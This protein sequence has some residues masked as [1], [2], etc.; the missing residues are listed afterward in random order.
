MPRRLHGL[1]AFLTLTS[2]LLLTLAP[3]VG[4]ALAE[5]QLQGLK[6]L[7]RQ[8]LLREPAGKLEKLERFHNWR[9]SATRYGSRLRSRPLPGTGDL[10]TPSAVSALRRARTSALAGVATP[11]NHLVNDPT[12]DFLFTCQSEVSIA[13]YGNYV[14]AAWNDGIGIEDTPETDTQGFGY[15]TDGGLTWVDTGV[16]ENLNVGKWN[17]DPVV[18]VNEKTGAFYFAALCDPS[19]SENGIGVVKGTFSGNS[20]S[21]GTPRV[22]ALSDNSVALL[23][24]NW[25]AVDPLTGNLYVSYSHFDV[26]LGQLVSDEIRIVRSID[27]GQIWSNPQTLSNPGDAGLV[28]GSRPAV[29]PDGEVYVVWHAI[30]QPSDVPN[31]NSPFG[32]DFLRVRKSTDDGATFGSE[33]TADSVFSNFGSGAPGFNRGLGITFPGIA[34]DRSSGPYRGRVYLTWNESLNF[35]NDPLPD[36]EVDFALARNESEPNNGPLAATPFVPGEV[37]RGERSIPGNPGDHDYWKFDGTQGQTVI[38]YLDS[39]GANLDA[40]FRMFCT[41]GITHLGF[42][43]NG[44][45]GQEL[46]VFTPPTTDT[47]Y[48]RVASYS[49]ARTGGYR[50]L[51]TLNSQQ[52]DRARDHRDI[53]VKGSDDGLSWGPTVR[54]NDS[55]GH[56][57][58]WLPEV[59]VDGSGRVFVVH[60]DFRDALAICGGGSNVYLARSDDGGATWISGIPVSDVTTNWSDVSSNLIPNQGDYIALFARDST[61]FVG[62]GDGRSYDPDVYVASGTFTCASAP[63]SLVGAQA[64]RD[65]VIVTWSAPAGLPATVYRRLGTGAYMGL[66]PVTGGPGDQIV[67]VDATVAAR[68]TYSYRLGVQGFCQPFVGEVTVRTCASAPV[69]LVGAPATMDTV[70]VTWSA[71]AGLLATVYRRLG[72][73]AYIDLGPITAGP[74]DQIVYVDASVA[75]GQT[76]SYR[77]GVQGFCE[78]FV[79]EVRVVVPGTLVSELALY[80]FQPNPAAQ[81]VNVSFSLAS[82]EPA[83]LALYDITGREVKRLPVGTMGPGPHVVNL[84]RGVSVKAGIYF[85]RLSQGGRTRDRRV[86]II[87]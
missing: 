55:A 11:P 3:G 36:P 33:V 14:V 30:G 38:F 48:I 37:L 66:G 79:G 5:E 42:S 62:W 4:A 31:G 46:L 28:Q 71:P 24:K 41:D 40:T 73:G 1:A 86:A 84:T 61:V 60:Y 27:D 50:I 80:G 6:L 19:S 32:R 45:G 76:Y 85:V 44:D 49:G 65:T 81:D 2:S 16:P 43:Q 34:V 8:I 63:V 68:Q 56:F 52:N 74:G 83:T 15:S 7:Q 58:D 70:V 59:A 72:T 69:S 87:L 39:L 51:T 23:D 47:Y 26:F 57:D 82:G 53:F 12:G 13:S 67:Y 64:T 75:A 21:W 77:L 17:S 18:V 25:M 9:N 29:G 22:A 54:V 35:Y 78:S 20:F 10:A